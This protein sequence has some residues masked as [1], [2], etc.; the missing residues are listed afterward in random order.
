[1]LIHEIEKFKQYKM[2]QYQQVLQQVAKLELKQ[3][4]AYGELLRAL[5]LATSYIQHEK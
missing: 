4:T 5:M 1:M 3:L 2:V